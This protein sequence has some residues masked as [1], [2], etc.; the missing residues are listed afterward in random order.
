MGR[1]QGDGAGQAPARQFSETVDARLNGFDGQ[2][3]EK[4]YAI[5]LM[6]MTALMSCN[7]AKKQV[8]G[9][10]SMQNRYELVHDQDFP[11]AEGMALKFKTISQ[12]YHL[13]II[14]PRH[15]PVIEKAM[16]EMLSTAWGEHLCLLL[17][18][19]YQI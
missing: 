7:P 11:N 9:R 17:S 10:R 18:G 5:G 13:L 14:R 19:I 15:R 8:N 4:V 6:E 12:R 2:A 1:D 3:L 16:D